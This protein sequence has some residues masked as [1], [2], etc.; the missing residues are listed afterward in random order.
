[1]KEVMNGKAA[2]LREV[3]IDTLIDRKTA[4]S[5]SPDA[6]ACL[7]PPSQVN[8]DSTTANVIFLSS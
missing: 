6:S 1:M 8:R 7:G 2:T 4:G 3:S 5:T